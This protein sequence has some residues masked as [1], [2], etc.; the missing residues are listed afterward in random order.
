MAKKSLKDDFRK[1][2]E[3][4]HD[5][6]RLRMLLTGV[7]LAIGYAGIYM[8]LADRIEGTARQLRE[9]QK[10]QDLANEVDFLQAQVE[11]FKARLPRQTDTNEWVNYVLDGTR[12]FPLKLIHLDSDPERRLG[13]YQAV[14]LHVKLEGSY[15]DLDSFLHWLESNERLFRVESAGV[16]SARCRDGNLVMQLT[17]LGMKG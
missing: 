6:F 12:R 2:F 14:V 11:R 5:P 1:L 15:R 4:L 17:V 16:T 10:L 13:P 3:Q 9:G 7:V 8:P